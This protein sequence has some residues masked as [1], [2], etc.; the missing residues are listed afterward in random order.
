VLCGQDGGLL[1]QRQQDL[2]PVV[3]GQECQNLAM[4]VMELCNTLLKCKGINPEEH[5]FK[6]ERKRLGGYQQKI[7]KVIAKKSLAKKKTLE[8]DVDHAN[9][10]IAAAQ[11]RGRA[12]SCGEGAKQ[13]GGRKKTGRSKK[14]QKNNQTKDAAIEF[15]S[16]LKKD[17][18]TTL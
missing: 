1:K 14:Q 6:N 5:S 18:Y 12:I 7:D 8:L 17:M 4:T 11:G 3:A 10:F 2:D 9:K 16:D 13:V 15:L